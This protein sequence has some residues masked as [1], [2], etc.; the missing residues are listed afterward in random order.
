MK[1][2]ETFNKN[3]FMFDYQ[4]TKQINNCQTYKIVRSYL[5]NVGKCIK[6]FWIRRKNNF[7]VWLQGPVTNLQVKWNGG[8]GWTDNKN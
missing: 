7:I 8:G 2:K 3:S 1:T 4:R 5:R 6:R